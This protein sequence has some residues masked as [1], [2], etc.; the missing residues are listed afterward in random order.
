MLV[1]DAVVHGPVNNIMKKEKTSDHVKFTQ[2]FTKWEN[3]R[4]GHWAKS[5]YVESCVNMGVPESK[6]RFQWLV[7]GTGI[8]G[9]VNPMTYREEVPSHVAFPQ[10]ITVWRKTMNTDFGS[11]APL[12]FDKNAVAECRF[13][14]VNYH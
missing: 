4:C 13:Q 14:G 10:T 9:P 12:K 7:S 3:G 11:H 5:C 1:S 6:H 2:T 8:N